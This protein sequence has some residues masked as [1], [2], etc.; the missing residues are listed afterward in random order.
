MLFQTIMKQS[1]LNMQHVAYAIDIRKTIDITT[2]KL[3]PTS[4]NL[5]VKIKPSK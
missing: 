1:L 3:V 2:F 5:N 4:I